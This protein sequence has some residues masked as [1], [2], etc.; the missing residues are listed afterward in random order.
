MHPIHHQNTHTPFCSAS[1]RQH[2]WASS[3]GAPEDT[4]WTPLGPP[5]LL[6]PQDRRGEGGESQRAPHP[7]APRA[8]PAPCSA[9]PTDSST[10]PGTCPG[11]GAQA[12]SS[13]HC[14]LQGKDG[15]GNEVSS[16]IFRNFHFFEPGRLERHKLLHHIH[17]ALRTRTSKGTLSEHRNFMLI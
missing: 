5:S 1:P 2:P 13:S 11:R 14:C 6:T 12:A 17:V 16:L 15:L 7:E 10:S 3:A 8:L 9:A 4:P